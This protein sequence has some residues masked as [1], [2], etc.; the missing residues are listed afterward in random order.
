MEQE[1]NLSN[2][3]RLGRDSRFF[4]VVPDIEVT[5]RRNHLL[6]GQVTVRTNLTAPPPPPAPWAAA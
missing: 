1:Q 4:D 6:G 3:F 2:E 5:P